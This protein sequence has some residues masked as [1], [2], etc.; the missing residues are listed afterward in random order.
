MEPTET[1]DAENVQG[2]EGQD[3]TGEGQTE[4]E[5]RV[6]KKNIEQPKKCGREKNKLS[7]SKLT[8]FFRNKKEWKKEI[9]PN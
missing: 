8:K 2:K 4:N 3:D 1:E 9:P 7:Q 5:S 6:S